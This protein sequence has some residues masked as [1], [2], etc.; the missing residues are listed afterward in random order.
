MENNT[1]ELYHWGIKGQKWGQRRYQN[2]DGSLTPAGQKRY[3]KEVEK[4]K[5]ETA[6]VKAAEKVIANK[7][8]VQ[9]KFDKLEEKKAALEARKKALKDGKDPEEEKKKAEETIE[10]KRERLLKSTNPKELYD[11]RDLLS[12]MELNERIN[13]IDT[14]ARLNS[15]IVIEHERTGQ[16]KMKELQSKLDTATATYKSIDNA[17]SAVV[18]SAIGKT[19]AKK[20]GLEPPKKKFDINEFWE[21]RHSKSAQ[22][23]MEANKWLTAEESIGKK[24]DASNERA[25]AEAEAKKAEKEAK[26]AEAEAKKVEKEAA[27]KAEVEAKKAEKEAAKEAK[28]SEKEAAKEAKKAEKEAEKSAREE[29]DKS[30]IIGEGTSKS[31]IK[32]RSESGHKWWEQ[33]KTTV[34]TIKTTNIG[35]WDSIK[36]SNDELLRLMYDM[37]D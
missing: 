5:K 6:K 14:E 17:Y 19:L 13:R 35:E 2:K 36:S 20:M 11:E 8:K 31:S 10:Q 32:E 9:N 27:K 29:A 16:E 33:N 37:Y 25:K 4:L 21:N 24:R 1:Q 7:K 30:E 23:M 3:N 12:T 18:N 28:K 34:N 26:K 22:E 15:K